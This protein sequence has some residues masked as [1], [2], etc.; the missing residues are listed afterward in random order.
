MEMEDVGS[1][2]AAG[3]GGVVP[4]L[5]AT[6]SPS[7]TSP[8]GVHSSG[9]SQRTAVQV[10]GVQVDCVILQVGGVQIVVFFSQVSGNAWR[11]RC[12][13]CKLFFLTGGWQRMAV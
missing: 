8:T 12:V 10:R 5:E 6:P 4:P 3:N 9:G 11:C 7:A 2:E 13:G 1:A